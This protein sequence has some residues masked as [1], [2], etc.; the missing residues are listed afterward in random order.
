[1][2][3]LPWL[4]SLYEYDVFVSIAGGLKVAEPAIDL[5]VASAI[6]S[7]V[8]NRP[9]IKGTVMFGEVGLLGDIRSVSFN[10][11]RIKEA[12][13]LNFNHIISPAKTK[14]WLRNVLTSAL[15]R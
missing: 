12:K 5:A 6:Y 8:K 13:N 7:S 1:M 15:S 9:F 14:K 10:A 11:K 3:T 4:I 2:K